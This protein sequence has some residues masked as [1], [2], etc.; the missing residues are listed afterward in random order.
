[1]SVKSNKDLGKISVEEN[2]KI[3][4][5]SLERSPISILNRIKSHK[6][7]LTLAF[8]FM[9]IISFSFLNLANS[10]VNSLN[11]SYYGTYPEIHPQK[12][13]TTI[14]S[15]KSSFNSSIFRWMQIQKIEISQEDGIL[16]FHIIWQDSLPSSILFNNSG[17]YNNFSQPNSSNEHFS[18]GY[19]SRGLLFSFQVMK[20]G[21]IEKLGVNQANN[22][23][24]E[25]PE[26]S[27]SSFSFQESPWTVV[28]K[29]ESINEGWF[30]FGHLGWN[31]KD[32]QANL[33][34]IH[35]NIHVEIDTYL[36]NN[37]VQEISSLMR[38]PEIDEYLLIDGNYSD[39]INLGLDIGSQAVT[40]VNNTSPVG[41]SINSIS[42]ARSKRNESTIAYYNMN[43]FLNSVIGMFPN[44]TSLHMTPSLELYLRNETHVS[45]A[46]NLFFS[47]YIGDSSSTEI[48]LLVGKGK[49]GDLSPTTSIEYT[50][51]NNLGAISEGIEIAFPNKVA[52]LLYYSSINDVELFLVGLFV[53]LH[54]NYNL[55]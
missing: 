55:N 40:L 22:G 35:Q 24:L 48:I 19:F 53:V 32:Y 9:I 6:R 31:F 50:M 34:F 5:S 28:Y 49:T 17:V 1:M 25:E 10:L 14:N 26:W 21:Q 39:W 11:S 43:P 23:E 46:L 16:F 2:S 41:L 45:Y 27:V 8:F 44:N 7:N 18:Q 52:P 13:W 20:K 47:P 29:N 30:G 4:S 54:F 51:D 12:G 42:L 33:T 3:M 36:V 15:S 38:I 37:F